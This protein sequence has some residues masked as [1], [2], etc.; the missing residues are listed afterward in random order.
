MPPSGGF[1]DK[2]EGHGRLGPEAP[3]L[4]VVSTAVFGGVEVKS[5]KG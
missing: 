3:V 2:T 5:K 1:G 4:K